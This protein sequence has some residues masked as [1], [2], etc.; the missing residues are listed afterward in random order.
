MP[1][2]KIGFTLIILNLCLALILLGTEPVFAES[3]AQLAAKLLQIQKAEKTNQSAQ[4]NSAEELKK[5]HTQKENLLQQLKKSETDISR[6]MT[7]MTSLSQTL[8]QSQSDLQDSK[9][10]L[11][12]ITDRL[13][14]RKQQMKSRLRAVYINGGASTYF[15]VLLGSRNF[16]DFVGRVIA[17]RAIAKQDVGLINDENRD[18]QLAEQK[19][20]E[21]VQAV[22]ASKQNLASLQ[23]LKSKLGE[24]KKSQQLV[25]NQLQKHQTELENTLIGKREQAEILSA[26]A[27]VV[28]QQMAAAVRV[29][30]QPQATVT[31]DPPDHSAPTASR[32]VSQTETTQSPAV[33]NTASSD[34]QAPVV[35]NGTVSAFIKPAAGVISSGFGYRS[36]DHEFHPG[37]DIANSEGTPI[38]AAANGVIFRAYQ[39]SS[40]GNCVMISHDIDGQIYTTVYAHMASYSVQA[41]QSVT[42]GQPI[43]VMGATGEAFGTHLHFE[44]Y[45]GSWTPPPHNGAVNPLDYIH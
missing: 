35:S 7:Q 3:K 42:Q 4:Q 36:F 21:I 38:L 27:A 2:R 6:T 5:T 29:Q 17:L 22:A 16:E 9:I 26:Q 31:D 45:V 40:Y 10:E 39:S 12:Q 1:M 43:G 33:E 28:K 18:Q 15:D 32:S 11:R 37:I 13:I 30:R 25:M 23:T 19:K 41:G 8:K 44:L 14:Q 20:Q 24:Q 34:Q